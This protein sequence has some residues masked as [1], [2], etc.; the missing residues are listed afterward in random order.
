[1]PCGVVARFILL[2][3]QVG[4]TV[5][6]LLNSSNKFV[7]EKTFSFSVLTKG[8]NSEREKKSFYPNVFAAKRKGFWKGGRFG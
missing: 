2:A 4:F 7:Q 1:V 3:L 6:E 5:Q 8:E